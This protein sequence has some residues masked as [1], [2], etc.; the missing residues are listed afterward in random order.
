M[1]NSKP[2]LADGYTPDDF[3]EYMVL[4]VPFF[5]ALSMIWLARHLVI[6]FCLAIIAQTSGANAASGIVDQTT[7]LLAISSLPALTVLLAWGKRLP[8]S[9]NFVRWIWRH[10]SAI[11]VFSVLLDLLLYYVMIPK[12]FD[13]FTP[14]TLLSDIYVLVYLVVSKRTRHVFSDFPVVNERL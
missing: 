2:S 6:P 12:L 3:N 10:A 4:K 8:Q 9:G 14:A 1:M 13:G 5:L 11:L 7:W